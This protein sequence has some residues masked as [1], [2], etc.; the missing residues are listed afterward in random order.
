M[1]VSSALNF[2]ASLVLKYTSKVTLQYTSMLQNSLLVIKVHFYLLVG[3]VLIKYW[4][5]YL[6]KVIVNLIIFCQELTVHFVNLAGGG[7]PDYSSTKIANSRIPSRITIRCLEKA[8]IGK[9]AVL[10]P[11]SIKELLDMGAE[12]FGIS[13]A[14]VLTEDGALIEDIEVIRDGDH[15]VLATSEN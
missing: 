5:I 13:L 8:H 12:K 9:R 11:D 14:K 15:L 4:T 1:K 3:L 7:G 6:L 10:L 2:E